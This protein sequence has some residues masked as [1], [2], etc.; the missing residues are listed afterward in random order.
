MSLDP[1]FVECCVSGAAVGLASVNQLW[2][3]VG[4]RRDAARSRRRR[5]AGRL[6]VAALMLTLVLS[7]AATVDWAHHSIQGV[8]SGNYPPL[9]VPLVLVA[10]GLVVSAAT[11]HHPDPSAQRP[12]AATGTT[13]PQSADHGS[14]TARPGPWSRTPTAH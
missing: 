1:V 3:A 14:A 12:G 7:V 11:R 5:G 6:M 4:A 10:I 8:R 13:D 2:S 9:L